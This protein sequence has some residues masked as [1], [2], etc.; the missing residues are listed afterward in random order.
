[1]V[2]R[3]LFA[4]AVLGVV[5]GMPRPAFADPA[6]TTHLLDCYVAAA[7]IDNFWYRSAAGLDCEIDY[8]GCVGAA[9]SMN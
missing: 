1:M 6:C 3:L 4:M 2:K 7:K 5:I 8:A 9:L